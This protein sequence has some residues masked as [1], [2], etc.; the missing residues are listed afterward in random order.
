MSADRGQNYFY[1]ADFEVTVAGQELRE[2]GV[3]G[4]LEVDRPEP[5]PTAK[6]SL[7]GRHI[8]AVLTGAFA[9]LFLFAL[10][11][12]D[13]SFD[14]LLR[15][16]FPM[17]PDGTRIGSV[18]NHNLW[19]HALNDDK[20]PRME[21]TVGAVT[22][23]SAPKS[24]RLVCRNGRAMERIAL[25]GAEAPD[26]NLDSHV[27]QDSLWQRIYDS[28]ER[29]KGLE[30]L[31][32]LRDLDSDTKSSHS[33]LQAKPDKRHSTGLTCVLSYTFSKSNGDGEVGTQHGAQ[34]QAPRGRLTR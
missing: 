32:V 9:G 14:A 27:Q 33:G 5:D 19:T 3:R 2:G 20:P 22:F 1:S 17:S 31:G 6:P 18:A 16:L 30:G 4:H 21:G 12:N 23:G 10:A 13:L 11:A 15:P 28:A 29:E 26:P 34:Y 24:K 8:G 7:R 25:V